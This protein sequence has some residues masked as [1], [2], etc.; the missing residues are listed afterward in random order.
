MQGPLKVQMQDTFVQLLC[1]AF[2]ML[3]LMMREPPVQ[4]TITAYYN[5][6]ARVLLVI[7]HD[8]PEVLCQNHLKLCGN[9]PAK[10]IQLRNIVLAAFPKNVILMDPMTAHSKLDKIPEM[11]KDPLFTP[12]P[13]EQLS[14]DRNL[15]PDIEAYLQVC[16]ALLVS[17]P[18]SN[19][20]SP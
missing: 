1:H 9:M 17:V 13:W 16:A 4:S 7:M 5:G 8:F 14:A 20:M 6:L 18:T 11:A 10:C 19:T 12:P 3:A 15:L 2:H